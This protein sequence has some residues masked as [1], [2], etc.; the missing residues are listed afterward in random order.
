MSKFFGHDD[1]AWDHDTE[2]PG[3]QL[4]GNAV[5][6][7]S[8]LNAEAGRSLTVAAAAEAFAVAPQ[9]VLEAVAAHYWMYLEG[10]DDDF[11]KMRIEHEGE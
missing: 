9:M 11:A 3:I 7:W 1:A 10:A 8:I 4:F 2:K 5:Q 6:V